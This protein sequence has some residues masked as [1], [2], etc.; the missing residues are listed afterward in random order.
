MITIEEKRAK[1]KD[2]IQQK[3]ANSAP[4]PLSLAQERIWFLANLSPNEAI[5]NIPFAIKIKGELDVAR[6]EES[7]NYLIAR[8]P[9][10]NMQ[11]GKSKNT[12]YQKLAKQPFSISLQVQQVHDE[13]SLMKALQTEAAKPISLQHP[14][15]YRIKIYQIGHAEWVLF[16]L[17][18]HIIFDGWSMSIFIRELTTIFYQL[19][20][21][22]APE[23]PELETSYLEFVL[24]ERV[25]F[26]RNS[27]QASLDYWL[28]KLQQIP[29]FLELPFDRPLPTK[30]TY[31]GNAE[32]LVIDKETSWKLHQVA[33]SEKRTLFSLLMAVYTSLLYRFANQEDICIGY[34]I[35]NRSQTGTEQIIGFFVNTLV[36]RAKV[37]RQQSFDVLWKGIHEQLLQDYSRSHVPFAHVVKACNPARNSAHAPIFQ[38]MF[39]FNNMRVTSTQ[40]ANLEVSPIQLHANQ[41]PFFQTLYVMPNA[42]KELV[43][44]LEYNTD[45]FDAAT[46]QSLLHAFQEIIQ[47]ICSAPQTEIGR[48]PLISESAYHALVN[49]LIPPAPSI[50]TE[51]TLVSAYQQQVEQSPNKLACY[52]ATHTFTYRQVDELSN[53]L[54]HYLTEQLPNETMNIGVCLLPSA[55]LPII[56][57]GIMKAGR[58]FVPLDTTF[59]AARLNYCI[60]TAEIRWIITDIQSKHLTQPF[61]EK[62][63]VFDE[64]QTWSNFNTAAIQDNSANDSAYILFTSGSTGNPKGV[65]GTH[66]NTMHR[67]HWMWEQYPFEQ[68]EIAIQRVSL[69]FVDAIWEIFGPLLK[70]IPLRITTLAE[71]LDTS[72]FLSIMQAERISRLTLVP[73]QLKVLLASG[74]HHKNVPQLKLCIVSGEKLEASLVSSFKSNFPA[75]LLLNLYGSTEVAGDVTYWEVSEQAANREVPIGW[76]IGDTQLYILDDWLE[77]LPKGFTGELYVGGKTLARGYNQS[78]ETAMRFLPNPFANQQGA[79]L[80]KTGDRVK[81]REDGALLYKGRV[82][83]L[84]KVRGIRIHPTE[85]EHELLKLGGI[86]DAVVVSQK[87]DG[88]DKLIAFVKTENQ[89]DDQEPRKLEASN[90]RLELSQRLPGYLLP[91]YYIALPHFPRLYNGKLNRNGFPQVTELMNEE[92]AITGI[93]NDLEQQIAQVWANYLKVTIHNSSSNFFDLGGDS[94]LLQQIHPQIQ[95]LVGQEL[96]VLDLFQYPTI[97]EMATLGKIKSAGYSPAKKEDNRVAKRKNLLRKHRA[98]VKK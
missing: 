9:V 29:T 98:R 85:I 2:L 74:F 33:Q 89:A 3:L 58:A 32:L 66:S 45:L 77:P 44:T 68:G 28:N 36:L 40:L 47:H 71:R 95:Q 83:D 64:D 5:F 69:N 75:T 12:A 18:H 90:Y 62:V 17:F 37:D 87:M 10:L 82:D 30:Q 72:S 13:H 15:Y 50:Q 81:F 59:P 86:R 16:L 39:V 23:L 24:H 14:P 49:H 31:N 56:L 26:Q 96:T 70:G 67:L 46:M 11:F 73:S 79:R 6:L 20:I 22:K 76:R 54:A 53:A 8:H 80:F 84:L 25:Q 4:I 65:I 34:P 91:D 27:H 48:L 93:F 88:F 61:S 52:D 55:Y 1:L 43:C 7:I 57:L 42:Q 63:L 94:L 35:A 78:T 51:S 41:S 21:G 60:A 97:A 92:V 19:S 38:V